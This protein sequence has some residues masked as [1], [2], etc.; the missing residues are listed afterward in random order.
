MTVTVAVAVAV[1]V[2]VVVL[3]WMVSLPRRLLVKHNL[4]SWVPGSILFPPTPKSG[5]AYDG[6]LGVYVLFFWGWGGGGGGYLVP[7]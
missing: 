4:P 2:A 6:V 3:L 7:G 5:Q 1:A